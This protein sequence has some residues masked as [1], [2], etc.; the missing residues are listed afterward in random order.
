MDKETIIIWVDGL[1]KFYEVN[2]KE[3][4]KNRDVLVFPLNE[5]GWGYSEHEYESHKDWTWKGK[6]EIKKLKEDLI[7][8]DRTHPNS[9]TSF[10]NST[11]DNY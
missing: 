8:Y 2:E 6:N 10:D 1:E 4:S 9:S 3:W 11:I 5:K 7:N